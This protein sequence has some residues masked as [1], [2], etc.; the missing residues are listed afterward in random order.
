[1]DYEWD[2]HK[3]ASNKRKHGVD[4]ADAVVV[5]EDERA[6]TVAGE[7]PDEER[8]MT[9]GADAEGGTLVVVYTWRNDR[10]RVISARRATPSERRE[11]ERQR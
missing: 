10:I 7:S 2:P 9:L 4:F 1:M 3:A 6:L 5:F 11:Y 8:F